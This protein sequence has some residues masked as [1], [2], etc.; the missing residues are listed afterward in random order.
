MT[1]LLIST[2]CLLAPGVAGAYPEPSG[3][4]NSAAAA[5]CPPRPADT[6]STTSTDVEL[7]TV[8]QEL[9]DLCDRTEQQDTVSQG[10]S[11]FGAIALLTVGVVL[12]V[13]GVARTVV[14]LWAN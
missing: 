3:L 6:T 8:E 10:W 1:A 13:A 14:S 5:V 2:A 11:E 4:S 12:I 7:T 9:A